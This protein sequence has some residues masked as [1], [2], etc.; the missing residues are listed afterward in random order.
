M[1]TLRSI[2]VALVLLAVSVGIVNASEQTAS[3]YA[4]V[5]S[6]DQVVPPV[7]QL[8]SVGNGY[9][10]LTAANELAFQIDDCW[11]VLARAAQVHI[12]GPALPGENGLVLFLLTPDPQFSGFSGKVGP[13]NDQQLHDL[14]CG[15]WYVDIHTTQYPFDY[16]GEVRGRIRPL[17]G[18][19]PENP[20]ALTVQSATW[21]A[22]KSLYR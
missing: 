5:L 19:H 16:F 8:P 21:G 4:C 15:L 22:V 6:G 18:W 1:S 9:F 13:L 7:S 12:H 17:L 11:G 20:C 2:V 10:G 3:A 14:N